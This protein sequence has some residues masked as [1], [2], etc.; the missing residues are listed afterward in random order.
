MAGR[1][2]QHFIDELLAR[3]DL[4]DVINARVQLRKA[5]KEYT[6]CCP[7]HNEKTPSFTVSPQKQFYHCFGCGAH[8]T[9]LS[10]LIEYENLGFV[11]AVEELAGLAGLELPREAKTPGEHDGTREL[12]EVLEQATSYFRTQL[13]QHPQA[14]RA[15][16]YL[17]K[18]GLSGEIAK[19][20]ELGYAPPGW[21][22]IM[23]ALGEGG[24]GY[25]RLVDAGLLIKKDDGGFYD[26]FRD[27]VMFPI[28]DARGRVIGFGGRVLGDETPKYLNSPETRLFHKGRELYGLYQARKAVRDLKRL[29]V[30][31]GY[32]D[33]VALAQFGVRNAVATLGT[34]TTAEH[35]ERLFRVVEEVVCCFDG[36]RAGRAA[37]HRA[38]EQALPLM[39]DGRQLRFIFLPEGED[40]DS[41]IRK[42]GAQ[43]FE[44]RTETG[45]TFSEFFYEALVQQVDM[46]SMD[47][48]ARLVEL[49]RPGL[50]KM[51][52]GALRHLMVGRLAEL[53][54]IE[55]GRLEATLGPDFVTRTARPKPTPQETQTRGGR[56]AGQL[57]LVRKALALLLARPAL[58]DEIKTVDSLTELNL[59]GIPLLCQVLELVQGNPNIK[60]AAIVEHWR[61]RDEW[62]HLCKL[63][64]TP[65]D[66]PEDGLRDEFLG[67]LARLEA[68]LGEQRLE[69]LLEKSRQQTLSPEEK[70]EM[71]R[72]LK[73]RKS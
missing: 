7:F 18:R 58:A 37:A 41:L 1:I 68:Q 51:P 28:R 48:R 10:F 53:A 2:P 33:V 62:R 11:E 24:R 45:S 59:P 56:P 54:K 5:G 49:A 64:L 46:D 70:E 19:E 69:A 30:V 29:L 66:I 55:T 40:P 65:L 26:R 12:Y 17:K 61:G 60:P 23:Q 36:D 35:L 73:A 47:G 13:R 39:S 63:M 6:A 27:R 44:R 38:L 43:A 25:R 3:V 42:E 67:V 21:D 31:E 8:G 72:L 57:S 22:G 15:V 4:V 71:G 9:A 34:A 52:K 16:E 14:E 32:M 20:F 50:Q